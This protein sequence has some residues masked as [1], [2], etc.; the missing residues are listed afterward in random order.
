MK[1]L[2][3]FAI[4]LGFSLAGELLH[5]LLPLPVPAS[6]YGLS[7]LLAALLSG[8]LP[9]EAVHEAGSF[10]IE[11]MPVLFV[12]AAVGLLESWEVLQPLWLPYLLIIV[13][14]TVVVMGISGRVTQAVIRRTDKRGE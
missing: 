8:L 2:R 9:L 4:I 10:L 7:L 3:Q 6:I 1:H 12:P 13:V 5:S 11:I 14:S